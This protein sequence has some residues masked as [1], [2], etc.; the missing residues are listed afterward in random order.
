MCVC[1]IEFT[2]ILFE[3]KLKTRLTD[4]QIHQLTDS[5]TPNTHTHTHIHSYICTCQ[6]CHVESGSFCWIRD[7]LWNPCV[8]K[9]HLLGSRR[10]PTL[11]PFIIPTTTRCKPSFAQ[12][13]PQSARNLTT[14]LISASHMKG[15]ESQNVIL[16]STHF[17]R[18]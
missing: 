12:S 14:N 16:F 17:L 1:E 11:P 6:I 13:K 5:T 15:R 3:R 8:S 4:L 18:T 7:P 2:C 10:Q 9:N